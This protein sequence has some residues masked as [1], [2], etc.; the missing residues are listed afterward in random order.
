[1]H[2]VDESQ[3]ALDWGLLIKMLGAECSTSLGEERV[4]RLHFAVSKQEA[5]Q[6][7]RRLEEMQQCTGEGIVPPFRQLEDLRTILLAVD[8]YRD[9]EISHLH[10]IRNH[11]EMMKLAKDWEQE[12]ANRFSEICSLLEALSLPEALFFLYQDSFDA[13]G[14][15]HPSQYPELYR[16]IDQHRQL[17]QQLQKKLPQLLLQYGSMLQEN[18][19]TKR[20]GRYVFPMKANYKRSMGIIHG[21][22]HSAQT[23]YVEPFSIVALS[24]QLIEVEA[25]IE[26]EKRRIVLLL[27]QS[28]KPY[29]EE[30]QQSLW[31]FATLDV[32]HAKEKLGRR[33]DGIIPQV[34]DCGEIRLQ[35]LRHPILELQGIDVVPNDLMLSAA[36][37]ALIIS[38][39]NAGGKTIALKALGLSAWMA[40]AGIPIPAKKRSK[41]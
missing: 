10:S 35:S 8:N 20:N 15:F 29:V 27:C 22:S 37:P 3:K 4:Q 19:Y 41:G 33:F 6:K 36:H 1:M 28:L 17:Q 21:C 40:K 26:Q 12:Y 32:I 14:R 39:P 9:V 7:Y 18:F 31:I 5:N 38:G 30:I 11:L 24:N 16:R 2:T 34:S 25:S 23:Y 13:E